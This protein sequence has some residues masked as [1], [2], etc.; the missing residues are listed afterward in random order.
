[1]GS[2]VSFPR[3]L[4]VVCT[5]TMQ[6][7]ADEVQ[8]LLSKTL[9]ECPACTGRGAFTFKNP[10]TGLLDCGP[11]PCGGTDEDRVDF[12]FGGAA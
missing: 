2:I 12:D 11:C 9:N 4:R 6:I 10:A 3:R 7:Q 1:M 8:A 5:E